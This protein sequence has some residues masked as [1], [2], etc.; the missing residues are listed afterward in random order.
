[1]MPCS[2]TL[3][4]LSLGR[5][6]LRDAW[7]VMECV[8]C[9][10]PL[11]QNSRMSQARSS[12]DDALQ[13]RLLL[14]LGLDDACRE[15]STDASADFTL[16]CTTLHGIHAHLHRMFPKAIIMRPVSLDGTPDASAQRMPLP[17]FTQC[18]V[19]VSS[20]CHILQQL[21]PH[22]L[23][24]TVCRCIHEYVQAHAS[25]AQEAPLKA[26]HTASDVHYNSN[27]CMKTACSAWHSA[28]AAGVVR[29]APSMKGKCSAAC[30]CR[31][32]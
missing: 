1:M 10:Q 8:T 12:A 4:C 32:A 18:E 17:N 24:A 9:R 30:H 2:S 23:Q 11:S 16:S 29:V 6:L 27:I 31:S 5:F 15:C 19:P 20:H 28:S 25:K 14:R 7:G 13:L 26:K 21:R 22:I 3:L